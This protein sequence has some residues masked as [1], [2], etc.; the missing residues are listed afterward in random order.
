ML[1]GMPRTK[2]N[3]KGRGLNILGKRNNL[4]TPGKAETESGKY[5]YAIVPDSEDQ[6]Y[7][8]FGIDG[9]TVYTISDGRVAAVVSDLSNRKIRPERRHLAA[10]QKVLK[11]LMEKCTPLPMTFGIIADGRKE[12]RKILSLNQRIFLEQLHRVAGKVEIGLR[13]AWDVP[14]IF[15]YFVHTHPELREARDR[16]FGTYR[17]PTQEDKIEVGR[18]FERILNE[19]REAHTERIEE[20]LIPHCFE[21]KRNPQ[22]NE[23]E[24]MNLACLVGREAQ[25]EFE[26][27]VFEAARLFDNNYS[28]DFNGP[29]APHNFVEVDLKF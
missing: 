5:L 20:I 27:G 29:W 14:N 26:A 7:G 15:E 8:E 10:H 25:A 3:D 16:F 23:A 28:F 12:I 1:T 13:V 17:E 22:K 18:M 19:D 21:I 2:M 4:Y 24:V 9:Y 6:A 11:Y